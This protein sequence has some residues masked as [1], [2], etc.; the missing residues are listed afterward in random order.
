VEVGSFEELGSGF[1]SNLVLDVEEPNALFVGNTEGIYRS[2]DGGLSWIAVHDEAANALALDPRTG[3][4]YAG[5]N[6]GLVRS[7]DGGD[8]WTR[9]GNLRSVSVLAIDLQTPQL[10]YA[11]VSGVHR[12]EDGGDSWVAA[13]HPGSRFP[14]LSLAVDPA[15]PG[16]VYAGTIDPGDL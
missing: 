13:G 2:Q 11:V 15:R 8:S 12:S 4:L 6:D 10:V 1:G 16:A 9:A 7:V 3:V 5:T 14:I